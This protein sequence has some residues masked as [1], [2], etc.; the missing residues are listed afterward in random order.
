MGNLVHT[1]TVRPVATSS[2]CLIII[3]VLGPQIKDVRNDTLWRC[4]H[5]AMAVD[6]E[7]GK[8]VEGLS[9]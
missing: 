8:L 3:M 4:S 7:Q 1:F 5:P 6:Q 2:M 9:R